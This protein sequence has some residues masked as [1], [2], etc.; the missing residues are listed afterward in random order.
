MNAEYLKTIIYENTKDKEFSIYIKVLGE[1]CYD[2][3][4]I[5]DF[6]GIEFD[7]VS[8]RKDTGSFIEYEYIPIDKITH[9]RFMKIK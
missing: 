6:I 2:V 5:K 7:C 1:I 8:F 4:P 3:I 9:V